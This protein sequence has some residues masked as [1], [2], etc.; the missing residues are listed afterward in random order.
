[1]ADLINSPA[2]RRHDIDWVRALAFILLI[3]YHIGMFYVADWGWHVKSQYQS[4]SLQLIMSLVNPWRMPLIFLVSGMALAA[5]CAKINVARI[6]KLRTLRLLI[7]GIIC[8]YLVVW[9]QAYFEAVQFHGYSDTATSFFMEYLNPNTTALPE[10]HHSRLG[11]FTWNHLW[12]LFYL[13]SYTLIFVLIK[14]MVDWAQPSIDN[15]IEKGKW[16]FAVLIL[17]FVGIEFYLEPWFPIT[18]ALIDDWYNHARYFLLMVLGYSLFNS[19]SFFPKLAQSRKV[20]LVAA[21]SLSALSLWIK[22]EPIWWQW[23]RTLPLILLVSSALACLFSILAYAYQHL[24]QASP[25]LDYINQAILPW[26]IVHQSITIIIAGTLMPLN[27]TPVIDFLLVMLG[28]LLGCLLSYELIKRVTI[29]K[30]CF[31]LKTT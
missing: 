4:D 23:G 9:P 11:L 26:Y 2:T 14:P 6:L 17:P 1:M 20:W 27:M 13:W 3:F 5:V 7:P 16:S 8:S 12:Y 10:M 22:V 24:N 18:H 19:R 25:A 31:G 28:T 21:L 30:F 29:L 15:L